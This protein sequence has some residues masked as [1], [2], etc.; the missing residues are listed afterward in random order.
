MK[1]QATVPVSN[2]FLCGFMILAA[3]YIAS[4]LGMAIP[5]LLI[6]GVAD[7][8]SQTAINVFGILTVVPITL[9]LSWLL[10]FLMMKSTFSKLYRSSEDSRLWLKKAIVCILPGEAF[11]YFLCLLTLGISGGTGEFAALVTYLFDSVYLPNVGRAYAVRQLGERIFSDYAGY[12]LCYLIYL[13][14]YL[15]GVLFL[16]RRIW[17]KRQKEH[18]EMLRVRNKDD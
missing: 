15:A 2:V 6:G 1:K 9:L 17:K 7:S 18:E 14:V 12:T 8:M 16:C 3:N 4:W 5:R 13:L 10:L 11:R